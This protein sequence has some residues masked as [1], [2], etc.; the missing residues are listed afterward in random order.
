MTKAN[1]YTNNTINVLCTSSILNT[2]MDRNI[3]VTRWVAAT[4][5][6]MSVRVY[7]T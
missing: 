3:E 6:S 2:N 1:V 4:W 7:E 5:L